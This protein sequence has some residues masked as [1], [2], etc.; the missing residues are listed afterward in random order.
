LNFA[1]KSVKPNGFICGHDYS[2]HHPEAL[3]AI[4]E[5]IAENNLILNKKFIDSS[6]AIKNNKQI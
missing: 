6:F 5:F 1:L 3:K 4:D 2:E